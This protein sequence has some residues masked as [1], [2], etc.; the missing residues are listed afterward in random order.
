MKAIILAGGLGTRLRPL[1]NTVPKPLLPIKGKPAMEWAIENLKKHGITEIVL[2]ISFFADK[3]KIILATAV[4]L[5][6][7]CYIQ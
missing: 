5:V 4:N 2:A 6:L 7:I 1:T 3:F